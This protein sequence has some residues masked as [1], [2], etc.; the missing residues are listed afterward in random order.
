MRHNDGIV[1]VCASTL[2]ILLTLFDTVASLRFN[3][4]KK[5]NLVLKFF[6][7]FT[8]ISWDVTRF[9]TVQYDSGH[10]LFIGGVLVT[11]FFFNVLLTMKTV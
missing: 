8:I 3:D 11:Q 2:G 6:S 9:Q 4:S 10:T 7:I 1:R 5:N